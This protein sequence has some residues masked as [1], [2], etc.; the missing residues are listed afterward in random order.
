[1]V[2][3]RSRPVCDVPEIVFGSMPNNGGHLLLDDDERRELLA[4][5]PSAR[6][7]IRRLVGSHEFINGESRWCLWLVDAS[8]AELRAM[9]EVMHRIAQ[10]RR[11][12]AASARPTTRRLATI[13]ALFGEIRQPTGRY[14]LVPSVS[15]ERRPY[16]PIGFMPPSVIASNL[17]LM[18]PSATLYHFGVLASA[19][20]MARARQVCGRLK[21]DYRYSNKLVYN[22]FPWPQQ[23]TEKQKSAVEQLAPPASGSAR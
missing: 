8:P 16:I 21:S 13:P 1:M 14:L 18:V 2:L 4:R 17:A 5:Q 15:S 19:M 7:F 20:H 9:P 23:P 10:V 6:K 22:N 3:S 12:R 11:H